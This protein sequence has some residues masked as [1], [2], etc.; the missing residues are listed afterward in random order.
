M[1]KSILNLFLLPALSLLLISL[2]DRKDSFFDIEI[3]ID[4]SAENTGK[5]NSRPTKTLIRNDIKELFFKFI[6]N[7]VFKHF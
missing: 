3:T 7:F 4:A 1:G 6:V 5:Q 2:Q